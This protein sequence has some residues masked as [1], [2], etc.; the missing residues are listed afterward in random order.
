MSYGEFNQH[1]AQK[2]HICFCCEQHINPTELYNSI[3]GKAND[4]KAKNLAICLCCSFLQTIKEG[5][6]KHTIVPG[7]FTEKKIPSCLRKVQKAFYEDFAACIKQYGKKDD[8]SAEQIEPKTIKKIVVKASQIGNNLINI[9]VT[10]QYTLDRFKV[11]QEIVLSAGVNG[12][13]RT[14]TIKQ[15]KQVDGK[16]FGRSCDCIALVLE[17]KK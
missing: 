9:P 2:R 12:Q 7:E 4:G 17:K 3:F 14:A 15:I 8:I 11:G 13:T 6:K 5:A 1:Q 16:S 10:K